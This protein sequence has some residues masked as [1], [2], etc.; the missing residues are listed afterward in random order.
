MFSIEKKVGKGPSHE[1]RKQLSAELGTVFESLSTH[2]SNRTSNKSVKVDPSPR[3]DSAARKVKESSRKR[4]KSVPKLDEEEAAEMEDEQGYENGKLGSRRGVKDGQVAMSSP[5]L[6][7]LT[8][9]NQFGGDKE[10]THSSEDFHFSTESGVSQNTQQASPTLALLPEQVCLSS[11]TL[12]KH[13][14]LSKSEPN[15]PILQPSM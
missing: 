14:S 2:N 11:L 12:I 1:A 4:S 5:S 15:S 3:Q 7:D 6:P 13:N 9:I 8:I 10:G